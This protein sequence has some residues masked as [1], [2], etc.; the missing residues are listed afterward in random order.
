MPEIDLPS[1]EGQYVIH[2]GQTREAAQQPSQ[3]AAESDKTVNKIA[4]EV[5]KAQP[6]TPKHH[7]S[8]PLIEPA[9]S[10][11]PRHRRVGASS[12]K[13]I[14]NEQLIKEQ[15]KNAF[16]ES[17]PRLQLKALMDIGESREA[18]RA[19]WKDLDFAQEDSI[20]YGCILL[21]HDLTFLKKELDDLTVGGESQSVIADKRDQIIKQ[22]SEFLN[23][24]KDDINI[25]GAD[26]QKLLNL[27]KE[28]NIDGLIK[29]LNSAANELYGM[30]DG[31]TSSFF[32]SKHC[33]AL[34]G[35]LGL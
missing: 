13:F 5:L 27:V 31:S 26:K 24:Y 22:A 7:H 4:V 32:A 21:A 15:I 12:G 33:K 11:T 20:S 9:H 34:K 14:E 19:F 17:T 18:V 30:I 28:G 6:L 25:S 23:N 10:E 3:A 8:T 35:S 29:A 1:S 2:S 16:G